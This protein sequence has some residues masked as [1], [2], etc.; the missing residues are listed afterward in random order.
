MNITSN[1]DKAMLE[2]I[3]LCIKLDVT[4]NFSYIIA[5]M[6]FIVGYY[7][8]QNTSVLIVCTYILLLFVTIDLYTFNHNSKFHCLTSLLNRFDQ[9]IL[10]YKCGIKCEKV[11]C[12]LVRLIPFFKKYYVV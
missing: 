12:I 2:K 10:L 6:N 9:R 3:L 4:I 11:P 7:Y 1:E 5:I 8:L